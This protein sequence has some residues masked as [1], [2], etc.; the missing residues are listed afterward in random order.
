MKKLLLVS[1]VL[2]VVAGFAVSAALAAE[3]APTDPKPLG[4]RAG[5]VMIGGVGIDPASPPEGLALRP[6][7]G[8]LAAKAIKGQVL[9]RSKMV[10]VPRATISPKGDYLI[11]FPEGQGS[12]YQG[13]QM[14]ALRSS[15]KGKTW[16]GPTVAFDSSQSHH[17][18]VPL[19]P[20]GSPRIYAF[21][22]QPIPGM[23]GDRSKGLQEN[24]PIG[25]RWSD[26]DGHNWSKVT[27]IRPEND[28]E[29]TGMS[30]VRM[31][32]TDA[33]TWLI[34][35]H[36][37]IWRRKGSP[38]PVTT[39][40]YILRSEDK[41]KTWQVLPKQRPGGWCL[42]KFD[43][44]DEGTV[45][46][47]GGKKAVV[48]VRTAEGHIWESGSDDDGR[49]WSDPKPTTLVHPDAPPMIFHL[50][51]G[52]TLITFIH[53]R[54]D[55]ERPHFDQPA[56][57]E[58]WCSISKDAGRTWGEPRFVFAGADA[59]G[60]I[61]SNSY[62]DMIADG[63]RIHIFLGQK[64][65]QLL[66]LQFDESDMPGF[67][68]KAELAAAVKHPAETA[69]GVERTA[70]F[71]A[72]EDGYAGFRIPG[73][74]VT[75]KGTVLAY[76]VG[77]KA[78]GDWADIDI[79]LRRSSDGGKT[80]EPRKKLGD[81]GASTVD[82]PTAIVDRKTG[83]VHMLYQVNYAR[84]F[85]MRS[86][87]DGRSFSEPV[88]I[89][90]VFEKFRKEYDWNVIAP[91]PGHGIQLANGRLIVP[92][93]LSTGGRRHR[94]S[95]VSVI[96]SDDHGGTWQRGDIV[97][98]ND[99]EFRNPSETVAVE[100]SDGRVMLNIR[101]ESAQSRRLVALSADGATG[102]TKPVFDEALFEP[103]CF[104]SLQRLSKM[105][106]SDKNRIL[107]V[108]PNSGSRDRRNLTVR[109][110]YD[111]GRS[112]PVRKVLDPDIAGYSDLAVSPDGSIYC[113]YERGG[114]RVNQYESITVA[115]FSLDWLTDGQ[116]T[117]T[118]GQN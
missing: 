11:L 103:V 1:G 3:K 55:P 27:L 86:D 20:R 19:I 99:A 97:V 13:K 93:W 62:L 74:V 96:Y 60:H 16:T 84:A 12:C 10:W 73:I 46:S 77:R 68:T 36:D 90:A 82:N 106:E 104:G 95:I 17:G 21:G 15:D 7:L 71:Q 89:T 2:L 5:A 111:E 47:L 40:Q 34:G 65:K 118:R 23:V 37:G 113:I 79:F 56:R 25:F 32:E 107:F 35:S 51:D 76:C 49:T 31:C 53:N 69:D 39:R 50:G 75:T 6:D 105:P 108:N 22:T 115:T 67:M 61:H 70:L 98:R 29:F 9:H 48:F 38:A 41:G 112:W 87:D 114:L 58:V 57:N 33:G 42:E 24:C 80:W 116:D 100:L 85:Y 78:W 52:K 14:L 66:Y 4:S 54:Y 28:P 64:G 30:C 101:S 8:I 18:F 117:Y 110:S 83:A 72:G 44:M 26:D 45:V 102:W 81:E 91:G 43:R 63:S 88:D 59:E 109:L 94:P 92:V